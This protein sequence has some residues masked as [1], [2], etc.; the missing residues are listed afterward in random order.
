[1]TSPSD[2]FPSSRSSDEP[3]PLAWGALSAAAIVIAYLVVLVVSDAG[4]MG[5]IGNPLLLVG[6]PLVFLCATVGNSAVV[7]FL[8]RRR[9]EGK[10]D[11]WSY[12]IGTM[13]GSV[14]VAGVVIAAFV[15]LVL[16]AIVFTAG[17]GA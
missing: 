11:I 4:G 15:I 9:L 10:V 3:H 1:M 12:G 13:I 17:D 14:V 16:L 6:I 2:S 7:Y 5:L 8:T